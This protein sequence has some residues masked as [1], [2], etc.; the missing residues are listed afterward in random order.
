MGAL[1]SLPMLS[2]MLVPAMS[3][4][5]TSLN[6]LFFY[7]TWTTLVLSHSPLK[8]EII[9]TAAVRLLFYLVPSLLFFLF[10]VL[11]PSAAV[12]LKTNGA[13]GL[14][15]GKKKK[16]GKKE[17]KVAAW[18][19]SNLLLGILVQ[20]AVEIALTKGLGMKSAL[21]VSTRLPLP[22]GILKDLLRGLL[23]REVC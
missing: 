7:I 12:I 13:D 1:L 4:Y 3:S 16:S 11:V 20:A 15:A 22:W 17:A 10:D 14:P 23:G 9:G 6:L 8:V 5:G 21:K 19:I 18:A 2:F